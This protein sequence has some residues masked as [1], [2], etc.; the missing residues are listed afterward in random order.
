MI[1]YYGLSALSIIHPEVM[2][3]FTDYLS[4]SLMACDFCFRLYLNQS[5]LRPLSPWGHITSCTYLPY[6]QNNHTQN[7]EES[8]CVWRQEARTWNWL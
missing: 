4:F 7:S 6:E 5:R 2:E 1:E 8:D 3:Q